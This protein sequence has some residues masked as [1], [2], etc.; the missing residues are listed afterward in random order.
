MKLFYV[1]SVK[2]MQQNGESEEIILASIYAYQGR[3][4]EA[5]I[6]FQKI[7][8][9]QKTLEIFTELKMFDQAQV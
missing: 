6:L 2:E 7:G 5:A 1:C 3:F 8:L 4:K 9:E